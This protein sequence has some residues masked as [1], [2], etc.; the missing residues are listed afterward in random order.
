MQCH[1]FTLNFT[2]VVFQSRMNSASFEE[3]SEHFTEKLA[4]LCEAL[5][6]ESCM[7]SAE[8]EV[9]AESCQLMESL[10]DEVEE[11]STILTLIRNK[12][13]DQHKAL[14]DVQVNQ[15]TSKY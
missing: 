2:P 4:G 5:A 9:K 3:L 8:E 11:L 1:K 15:I 12:C 6:I 14:S 7:E 13:T 10:W